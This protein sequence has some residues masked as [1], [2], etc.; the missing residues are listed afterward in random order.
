MGELVFHIVIIAVGAVSAVRGFNRGILR[1]IPSVLGLAFG[2]VAARLLSPDAE[3]LLRGWLPGL[4]DSVTQ[5]FVYPVLADTLL[6]GLGYGLVWSITHP[7]VRILQTLSP[8]IG[9]NIVGSAFALFCGL[10][11][12]SAL[13]NVILAL[14]MS[15]TLLK[16]SSQDDGN[17]VELVMLISPAL[18]GCEDCQELSHRLQLEKAKTISLNHADGGNVITMWDTRRHSPVSVK[19]V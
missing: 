14:T 2:I 19:C 16:Y 4:G 1:Q 17:V 18:T 8:G 7:L 15:G 5:C 3:A 10:T 13:L 6:L 9:G 11:W 12:T